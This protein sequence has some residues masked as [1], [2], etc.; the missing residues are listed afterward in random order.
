MIRARYFK[1][2]SFRGINR[3]GAS[4]QKKTKAGSR[5]ASPVAFEIKLGVLLH[6]TSFLQ[7]LIG[8]ALMHGFEAFG[9]YVDGD[10][11]AEFRDKKGLF[12]HVDLA[13]TV[14][15]RVVF[16]RTDA[17]RIPASDDRF[18]ACYNAFP[19]HRAC[20]L[21]QMKPR[22]KTPRFEVNS[23]FQL[24][25]FNQLLTQIAKANMQNDKE[26]F[27]KE[28]IARLI[29]LTVRVLRYADKLRKDRNLWAVAD[30]LIRCTGSI[31]ANVVEARGSASKKDYTR[32]FEIALKSANETKYWLVVVREYSAE[33]REE[34]SGMLAEVEQVA[35]IIG[36]SVLTLKGKR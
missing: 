11:L 17:V 6:K 13:A 20:N 27:K 30:Q 33:L 34:T 4:R 12:L 5:A 23:N 9:G 2:Y 35:N 32:F 8:S 28:F 19:G 10:A 15:R 24:T 16:G 14:P 1:L 36:S 21:P 26:K 7:G 25:I 22:C 31:G 29:S 3:F 18:L